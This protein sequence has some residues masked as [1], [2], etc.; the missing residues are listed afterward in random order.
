MIH[1][2]LLLTATKGRLYFA[3]K[4]TRFDGFSHDSRQIIPG[5]MFVAVRGE[6][7]NGHDYLSDA[8]DH[9]AAGLLVEAHIINALSSDILTRLEQ[10]NV[11]TIVVDDTRS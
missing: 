2:D 10:A 9:G 7:G 4:Q 8:L 5:E 11:A 3:G 6:R 1:L